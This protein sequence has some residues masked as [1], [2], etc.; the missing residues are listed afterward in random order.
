MNMADIVTSE[1]IAPYES[2]CRLIGQAPQRIL[3][4]NVVRTAVRTSLHTIFDIKTLNIGLTDIPLVH[5]EKIYTA[6]NIRIK[7]VEIKAAE[8]RAIGF[9]KRKCNFN[10]DKTHGC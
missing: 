5:D 8:P 4:H 7:A 9:W 2:V 3:Q 10:V 6:S 1:G